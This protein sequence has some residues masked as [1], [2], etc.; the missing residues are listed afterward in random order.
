MQIQ[1]ILIN[2]IMKFDTI[3][4]SKNKKEEINALDNM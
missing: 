1:F 2:K 3:L 4:C